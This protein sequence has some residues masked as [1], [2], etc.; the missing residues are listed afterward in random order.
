MAVDEDAIP[1][2]SQV[3]Q[4]A[5]LM[6]EDNKLAVWLMAGLGL[7]VS[8]ALGFSIESV[9]GSIVRL[10]HQLYRYASRE[11]YGK[12][13]V[14]LKHRKEGEY[15]DI[16]LPNRVANQID[17]HVDKFGSI[18]VEGQHLLFSGAASSAAPV[19]TLAG[20]TERWK[21][22]V[23][24]VGMDFTPHDLRHYYASQQLAG[25]AN[26][27]EVSRWLGHKSIQVTVDVYGHLTED[28]GERGRAIMDA[29]LPVTC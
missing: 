16:P 6:R 17:Q 19:L 28:A 21:S 5:S 13:L 11:D 24:A 9:R 18:E 4:L 29:V 25:G 14:K 23:R 12:Y 26:I 10:R 8:E 15:R 20:M 1:N 2:S 3:S 27:H 22:R 7:R